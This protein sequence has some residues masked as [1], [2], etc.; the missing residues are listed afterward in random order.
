MLPDEAA[1]SA[2]EVPNMLLD[3]GSTGGA[4]NVLPVASGVAGEAPNRLPDDAAGAANMLPDAT[5]DVPGA[6]PKML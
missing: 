1:G 5:P 4:P 2:V 6:G 3:V